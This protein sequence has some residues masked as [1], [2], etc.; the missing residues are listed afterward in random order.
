MKRKSDPLAPSAARAA[1]EHFERHYRNRG[2]PF[3][4]L[5]LDDFRREIIGAVGKLGVT[6]PVHSV[7]V[8]R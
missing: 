5:V 4:A 7:D 2:W 1:R 8:I 3:G 6:V